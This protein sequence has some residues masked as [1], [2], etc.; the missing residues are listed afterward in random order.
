M[1]VSCAV[2]MMGVSADAAAMCGL[3]PHH[4]KLAMVCVVLF[5]LLVLFG[6]SI[7]HSDD[8]CMNNAQLGLNLTWWTGINCF[9]AF[10]LVVCV[11]YIPRFKPIFVVWAVGVFFLPWHVIGFIIFA[12]TQSSCLSGGHAVGIAAAFIFAID[13]VVILTGIGMYFR[14]K[15]KHHEHRSK[16]WWQ[17]ASF[18]LMLGVGVASVIGMSIG[19]SYMNDSCLT[20]DPSGI[21]LVQW[22]LTLSTV[23][24]GFFCIVG[25][26]NAIS[27]SRQLCMNYYQEQTGMEGVRVADTVAIAITVLWTVFLVVWVPVGIFLVASTQ[28]S[29][30]TGS[31]SGHAALTAGLFF[32]LLLPLAAAYIVDHYTQDKIWAFDEAWTKLFDSSSSSV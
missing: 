2:F 29:C 30:I 27:H 9:A 14:P 4:R 20:T 12:T 15:P 18:Y 25:V 21:N 3:K 22:I 13:V 26:T 1:V 5:V 31:S 23:T 10:L 7:V 11:A 16:P 8:S 17:K 24:F 28:S 19:S 32:S 6:V